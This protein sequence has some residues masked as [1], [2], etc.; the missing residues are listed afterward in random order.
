MFKSI[1]LV[2]ILIF[3]MVLPVGAFDLSLSGSY[4][5][6][7]QYFARMGQNDLFGNVNAAQSSTG[8]AL[9]LTTI[10]LAGPQNVLGGIQVV[11]EGFSSKGSAG[12]IVQQAMV[13][14]P[15]I[16]V[17]SALV[18]KG[19]Y[20]LQGNI[21]AIPA[22]YNIN[23]INGWIVPTSRG[24]N[25]VA[26]FTYGQWR[27]AWLS[28]QTPIGRIDAGR[29]PFGFGTGW[30]GYHAN[31]YATSSVALTVPY[32]PLSFF[33]AF[34]MQDTGESDDRQNMNN[35]NRTPLTVASSYDTTETRKWNAYSAVVYR[36][37][38]VDIGTLTRF[39]M[40][41][42]IH[43][44]PTPVPS[45]YRDDVNGSFA[46]KFFGPQ[47]DGEPIYGDV[48]FWQQTSYIKY[49]NGRFFF[50]AEYAFQYIKA[51]REGGRMISGWPKSAMVEMGTVMG[52][53]KTTL[54]Y[55]YRSGHERS[56]GLLDTT[57]E[58][59]TTVTGRQVSDKWN[60]FIIF[61][62]ASEAI[63]PYTY[64][65]D[66]YGTGNN[67]YDVNGVCTYLDF[68]GYAIRLDWAIAAN[69]NLYGSFLYA[70][71]ASNS[72]SWWGQYAGDVRPPE[73]TGLDVPNNNLGQEL[74]IGIDWKLIENLS[75]NLKFA[76]WTPGE[77]FKYAYQSLD[78]TSSTTPVNDNGAAATNDNSK[79]IQVNPAR[80]IDP[81]M[82][83]ELAMKVEF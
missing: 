29:R 45:T 13:L 33:V 7:Y 47:I 4:D 32:G 37:G 1:L 35:A 53:G 80:S 20:A 36:E 63:R 34:D 58:N 79:N 60:Q 52:P 6:R 8:G 22:S 54:A 49:F 40:Y 74:V 9:G 10:G 83:I 64:L 12:A 59:G 75:T 5:Y 71:R 82:G 56:G 27:A 46:A 41:Q 78:S 51:N 25:I 76:V 66:M 67:S 68:V 65:I 55:F 17:N 62:G 61:G 57:S 73:V 81:I 43:S 18:V 16:R 69:L 42:N 28:V 3:S 11:P 19:I 44:Y 70:Q 30:S 50:N 23:G 31:E 26:G 77:W 48:N 24:E 38:P 2:A 72:G 39:I 14:Y 15:T 21:N